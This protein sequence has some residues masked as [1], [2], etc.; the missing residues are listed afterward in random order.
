[1]RCDYPISGHAGHQRSALCSGWQKSFHRASKSTA[2]LLA[3][4]WSTCWPSRRDTPFVKPWRPSSSTGQCHE[5]SALTLVKM[6]CCLGNCLT[7]SVQSALLWVRM[8]WRIE[9][10]NDGKEEKQ[11]RNKSLQ[12]SREIF[13]PNWHWY[14]FLTGWFGGRRMRLFRWRKHV[15]L[16]DYK[17]WF[18]TT[19]A[20]EVILNISDIPLIFPLSCN[21]FHPESESAYLQLKPVTLAARRVSY[22]KRIMF[23]CVLFTGTWTLW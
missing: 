9:K 5:E 23:F 22:R 19:N 1:M 11:W 7:C 4:S 16:Q 3:S 14:Y 21:L 12:P 10:M 20:W 8:M 17:I 2:A 18:G 13:S 6:I 15:M